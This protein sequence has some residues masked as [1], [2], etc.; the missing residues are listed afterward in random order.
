MKKRKTLQ[1]VLTLCL[2]LVML[3]V[4]FASCA[5]DTG[6]PVDYLYEKGTP[7]EE[8]F[9]KVL[10]QDAAAKEKFIAAVKMV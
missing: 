4:L 6:T 8:Y 2:C 9:A 7:A 3:A 5:K 1:K 10:N